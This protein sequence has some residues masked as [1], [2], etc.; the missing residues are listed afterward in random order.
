MRSLPPAYIYAFP[1]Y[2]PL[3]RAAIKKTAP[4]VLECHKM[5]LTMFEKDFIISEKRDRVLVKG[6]FLKRHRILEAL[7]L[8][9]LEGMVWSIAS[10]NAIKL[11][12]VSSYDAEVLFTGLDFCW[13]YLDDQRHQILEALEL[14]SLEGTIW[15]IASLNAIKLFT[16]SSY[17]AGVAWIFAGCILTTID[18][19]I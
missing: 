5:T 11:S 2:D 3:H 16:V 19:W 7:E 15:S 8:F 1:K 13:L 18:S 10:L 12:T 9:S 6:M 14:S 17:D 4:T